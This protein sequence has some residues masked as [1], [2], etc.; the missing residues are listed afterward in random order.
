MHNA[1]FYESQYKQVLNMYK[2]L[3]TTVT[4][5]RRQQRDLLTQLREKMHEISRLQK[6][7]TNA[8][9]ISGQTRYN[10]H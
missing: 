1:T 10:L 2:N 5:I 6:V 9:P 7:S 4:D 3:Q 8:P